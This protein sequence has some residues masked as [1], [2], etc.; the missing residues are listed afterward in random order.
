LLLIAPGGRL[1]Y[2]HPTLTGWLVPLDYLQGNQLCE[3]VG[4]ERTQVG[5][6]FADV[7]EDA[8][9]IELEAREAKRVCAKVSPEQLPELIQALRDFPVR[10]DAM[11]STSWSDSEP[12]LME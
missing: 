3:F 5:I 11:P 2:S 9:L 1:Y 6:F 10:P 7:P 12:S 8:Q 4:R